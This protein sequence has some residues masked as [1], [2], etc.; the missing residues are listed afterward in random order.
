MARLPLYQEIEN[1]HLDFQKLLQKTWTK[2]VIYAKTYPKTDS[3]RDYLSLLT[4]GGIWLLIQLDDFM[5]TMNRQSGK[6]TK[7]LV[8]SAKNRNVFLEGFDMINRSSYLTYCMF[9]TE[10]FVKDVLNKLNQPT[11]DGYYTLTKN[12]LK[13]LNVYDDQKH[14]T[15]TLPSQVRNSLHNVGYTDFD[16]D[17]TLRGEHFK[18]K[19]GQQVKFSGWNELYIMIDEMTDLIIDLI[20]N[21]SINQKKYIPRLP[22]YNNQI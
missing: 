6:I 20:E 2:A 10:H 14:K 11:L 5:Y 18:A 16:I 22:Q 13:I 21:S 3:R 19:K 17:V 15:L 1:A 8:F 9:C 4:Q 12:L 7:Y